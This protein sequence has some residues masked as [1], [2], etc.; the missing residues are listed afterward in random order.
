MKKRWIVTATRKGRGHLLGVYT[1]GPFRSKLW[2][3]ITAWIET[4]P[5]DGKSTLTQTCEITEA[6]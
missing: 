3:R 4:W 5:D 1:L 6:L 2:A